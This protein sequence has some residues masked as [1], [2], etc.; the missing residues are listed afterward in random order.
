[1]TTAPLNT[2]EITPAINLVID[3]VWADDVSFD[4][5]KSRTGYPEGEV[6][7]LM[8]R[9]LKPSSFRMWR[10]RVSGRASKHAKKLNPPSFDRHDKAD[11]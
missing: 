3:L 7:K 2:A 11:D 6:I 5:I 8:R 9:H 10:K 1:M 4:E